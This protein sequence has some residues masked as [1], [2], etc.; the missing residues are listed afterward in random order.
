M[1]TFEVSNENVFMA[2]FDDVPKKVCK[3]FEEC[4]KARKEEMQELLT[5]YAKYHR[6]SITQIKELVLPLIDAIKEVH[7]AKVLHTSTS[8]TLKDVF[9]MF[10][11]H[12]KFTRNM[13]GEE[14]AKG[15]AMFSQNSKYQ[16]TTF[17][18]AHPMAPSSSA[19]PNTLVTQ[20]PYDML[21]NYYGGQTPPAQNASM[22]L[23][24]SEPV[25]ISSIPPTSTI[26]G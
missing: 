21:L 22:T 20:L 26:P 14:I 17:A 10:F 23:Y 6:S 3:A 13:V 5:C 19:T 1:T 15:L 16:P 2:S 24:T 12:V 25:P 4:K 9:A 7:T 11:E 8:I 18:S